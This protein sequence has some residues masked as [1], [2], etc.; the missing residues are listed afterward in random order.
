MKFNKRNLEEMEDR[1]FQ[2]RNNQ[3]SASLNSERIS[4]I[5]NGRNGYE[6]AASMRHEEANFERRILLQN[7]HRNAQQNIQSERQPQQNQEDAFAQTK[8]RIVYG[9]SRQSGDCIGFLSAMRAS[10]SNL[11]PIQA[12]S[13]VGD[14]MSTMNTAIRQLDAKAQESDGSQDVSSLKVKARRFDK[15]VANLSGIMARINGCPRGAG[16]ASSISATV[17]DLIRKRDDIGRW[18]E[19]LGNTLVNGDY[20]MMT[21]V[22]NGKDVKPS[23]LGKGSSILATQVVELLGYGKDL[24]ILDSSDSK[25]AK[26]ILQ[27]IEH[28]AK[29][30]AEASEELTQRTA[31]D[32]SL[33]DI[34]IANWGGMASGEQLINAIGAAKKSHGTFDQLESM[35]GNT[36]AIFDDLNRLAKNLP[37]GDLKDKLS[38][39]VLQYRGHFDD[40]LALTDSA[41]KQAQ[42]MLENWENSLPYER[43]K[44]LIETI[45]SEGDSIG[46]DVSRGTNALKILVNVYLSSE[47]SQMLKTAEVGNTARLSAQMNSLLDKSFRLGLDADVLKKL[48]DSFQ[49]VLKSGYDPASLSDFNQKINKVEAFSNASFIGVGLRTVA[50]MVSSLELIDTL[51]TDEEMNGKKALSI[52]SSSVGLGQ[53]GVALLSKNIRWRATAQSFL[54]NT[55]NKLNAIGLVVDGIDLIGDL[56][57]GEYA[58]AGVSALGILGGV[59]GFTSFSG[60]GFAISLA[61]VVIGMQV[62]KVKTSNILETEHT[63]AFLQELGIPPEV[64]YHLRNA[65]SEGRSIGNVL[66]ALMNYQKISSEQFLKKLNGLSS[67]QA[68]AL[69]EACHGVDPRNDGTL[70]QTDENAKFAGMSQEEFKEQG[71]DEVMARPSN[72]S[73]PYSSDNNLNIYNFDQF[74]RPHSIEGLANFIRRKGIPLLN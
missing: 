44:S 55:S 29:L 4:Q 50:L 13:I 32:Q 42:T 10:I 15:A 1:E 47:L 25:K 38:E 51:T 53:A 58:N 40:A 54:K 41:K 7:Q 73:N 39:R 36:L 64:A 28:G 2:Q 37:E 11:T 61:A 56:K 9:L 24:N 31:K 17:T 68:N 69:A 22:K 26:D 62:Q 27:N 8:S 71:L 45:I 60:V 14:M 30:L 72:S 57:D 23:D 43:K 16:L 59:L 20:A 33:I 18:D 35:A 19:A 66:T 70:P 12:S 3:R 65:D 5:Q 21:V 49:E 34:N 63:E 48:D 67:N 74:I 6:L 46:G 52:A